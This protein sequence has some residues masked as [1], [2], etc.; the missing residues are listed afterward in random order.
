MISF[1]QAYWYTHQC[2]LRKLKLP[3]FPEQEAAIN[4]R[5]ILHNIIVKY[6][7]KSIT[8]IKSE[9][10]DTLDF[11]A[12]ATGISK[13]VLARRIEQAII[14]FEIWKVKL[15][16]TTTIATHIDTTVNN[17]KFNVDI[18]RY[19]PYESRIQ[20]IWFRYDTTMPSIPDLAKLVEKAQWNA[21]GF[22]IS[23]KERPMQLTYF[24][25]VLGTDY[26]ILYNPENGYDTVASLIAD[27]VYYTRP[28]KIC[29]I[30]NECPMT[31]AGYLG[32]LNEQKD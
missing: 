10:L 4:L 28:G 3:V 21:R 13:Q 1:D 9:I 20:L 24:F 8:D 26:S 30:C 7:N 12:V 2:P 19:K 23:S 17:M 22:E 6:F 15:K 31:W 5:S 25:P 27:Q 32:E 16:D 14:N 29:D 11:N 18:A